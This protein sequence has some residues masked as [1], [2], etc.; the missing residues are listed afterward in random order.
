MYCVL[1]QVN[2]QI[3]TFTTNRSMWTAS[4]CSPILSWG[5]NYLR[6][7]PPSFYLFIN[8]DHFLANFYIILKNKNKDLITVKYFCYYCCAIFSPLGHTLWHQMESL[9]VALNLLAVQLASCTNIQFQARHYSSL[10]K[11][12]I[13]IFLHILTSECCV[14]ACVDP[15]EVLTL[16]GVKQEKLISCSNSNQ[17]DIHLCVTALETNFTLC[18]YDKAKLL[19]L[20]CSIV[21]LC[22]YTFHNYNCF[23]WFILLFIH[24]HIA[25]TLMCSLMTPP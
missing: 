14:M 8:T 17:T 4:I 9:G 13:H 5:I 15:S 22:K 16:L 20:V 12:S 1:K 23:I 6:L 10:N 18:C 21:L 3:M 25:C 24:F 7:F 2:C 11:G 19:H